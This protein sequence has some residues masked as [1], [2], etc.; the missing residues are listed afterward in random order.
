MKDYFLDTT[1]HT[2]RNNGVLPYV[3]CGTTCLASYLSWLNKRFGKNYVCDDDKVLEA[4]NS[5]GMLITAE[6]MI[7]RGVIDKSALNYRSDNPKT[8]VDES[9]FTHLNNFMEMLAECGNYLTNYEFLFSIEYKIP[10]DIQTVIDSKYPAIIS[11]KFT[12]GG[13]FVL[14]VGYD[15]D[16]NFI[17]D[18]PYGN[19]N[20][21]YQADESGAKVKYPIDKVIE[22]C[23]YKKNK[24]M[25][26]L[27]ARLN[28]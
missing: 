2:Q 11:A 16:N 19:W 24:A 7:K 10:C 26:I 3:S 1:Y 12:P 28:I 15:L 5:E 23:T 20:K 22:V 21:S 14:V 6:N 8:P 25:R 18:D 4:L 27:R 9:K 17:V 13:H